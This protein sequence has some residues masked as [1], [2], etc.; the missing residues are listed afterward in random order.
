VIAIRLLRIV[1]GMA[2]SPTPG[3]ATRACV[4]GLALALA[5][6]PAFA[7]VAAPAPATSAPPA[8]SAPP[9]AAPRPRTKNAPLVPISTPP[10]EFPERARRARISGYVIVTYT[11]G[12]DGRVGNVRIVESVP[13][14]VFEH[15]VETTLARW[16]YEPPA[17][18]REIT[19]TFDFE[20]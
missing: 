6:G 20:Q 14:G 7:A 13:K 11:I 4:A 10:P 18:A 8:A 9:V 19:H 3:R 1:R 17:T 2:S 5:P 15:E 12:T 16:R